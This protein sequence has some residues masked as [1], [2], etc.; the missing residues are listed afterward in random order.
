MLINHRTNVIIAMSF[1]QTL[2]LTQ[3]RLEALENDTKQQNGHA[4]TIGQANLD[5]IRH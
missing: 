3:R 5:T 1:F 2:L 4:A